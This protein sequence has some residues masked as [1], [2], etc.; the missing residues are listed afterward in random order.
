MPFPGL[1]TELNLGYETYPRFS[2]HADV[3]GQKAKMLF[4]FEIIIEHHTIHE[5]DRRYGQ[6]G[7]TS[8]HLTVFKKE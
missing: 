7:T 2:L 6:N 3:P 1:V 5:N 4:G 8:C